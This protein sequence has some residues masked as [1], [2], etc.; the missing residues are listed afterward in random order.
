MLQSR[1]GGEGEGVGAGE[2]GWGRR[3][4]LI[5]PPR[6]QVTQGSSS[7]PHGGTVPSPTLRRGGSGHPQ[8]GA[9]PHLPWPNRLGYQASQGQVAFGHKTPHLWSMSLS[10]PP[11]PPPPT[12]SL[13]PPATG[14]LSLSRPPSLSSVPCEMPLLCFPW[15]LAFLRRGQGTGCSPAHVSSELRPTPPRP[16]PLSRVP[17][18]WAASPPLWTTVTGSVSRLCCAKLCVLGPGTRWGSSSCPP[19]VPG[20]IP[21]CGCAMRRPAV[22][23][24]R[25]R[26]G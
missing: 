13:S 24:Q 16:Q 4:V 15:S 14:H 26:Q 5:P 20:H 9:R 3:A 11:P 6:D 22:G 18:V 12:P 19:R 1:S 8:H 25:A 7:G 21:A 23:P 2:P 17:L 10:T